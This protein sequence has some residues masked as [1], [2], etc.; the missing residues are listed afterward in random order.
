MGIGNETGGNITYITM[1]KQD[2]DEHGKFVIKDS[3][4]KEVKQ[5][6]NT[7]AGH[8]VAISE[9]ELS[10]KGEK[11]MVVRLNFYDDE[12]DKEYQLQLGKDSGA[13]RSV[14]N[15]LLSLE[16]APDLK[17][18]KIRSYLKGEY[19]NF[20]MEKAGAKLSWAY[21]QK[22]LPEPETYTRKGK[23]EKDFGPVAKFLYDSLIEKILPLAE[24]T[25]EMV[26]GKITKTDV[27][28]GAAEE[29]PAKE[30]KT[31]EKPAKETKKDKEAGDG[32]KKEGKYPWEA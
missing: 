5:S 9:K 30:T 3:K 2:S 14:A 32:D 11:N 21:E 20:Y 25:S 13:F 17:D 19:S 28:D 18:I 29:K 15:T 27:D 12:E 24:K 6:F 22:E 7:I 16:K 26:K 1:G 4:T 31:E 23:E 10:Y 8:I